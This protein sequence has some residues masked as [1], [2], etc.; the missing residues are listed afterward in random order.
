MSDSEVPG[1][2]APV[3]YDTE[4][5][6]R[7]VE[8]LDNALAALPVCRECSL[9]RVPPH[10]LADFSFFYRDTSTCDHLAHL[11]APGRILVERGFV[12]AS[13]LWGRL[14]QTVRFLIVSREAR[15]M[16]AVPGGVE[17]LVVILRNAAFLVV[18]RYVSNPSH[19][20][21]TL[22]HIPSSEVPE[23]FVKR[24]SNHEMQELVYLSRHDFSELCACPTTAAFDTQEWLSRV[25]EPIGMDMAG[26]L[27]WDQQCNILSFGPEEPVH[28]PVGD[29]DPA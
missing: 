13:R 18:D 6:L 29:F 17:G 1:D 16:D 22:L 24:F 21:I 19:Q 4:A 26:E 23:E 20:Q 27:F 5:R 10:P 8:V 25:A 7:E 2:E 15:D 11:Y 3:G 14:K 28:Y 9:N 12:D